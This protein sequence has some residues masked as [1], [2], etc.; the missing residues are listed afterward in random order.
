MNDLG[1]QLVVFGFTMLMFEL[2]TQDLYD[3]RDL[4][5]AG[6]FGAGR[7]FVVEMFEMR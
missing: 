5:C 1:K 2:H 3:T 7:E 6:A 4:D